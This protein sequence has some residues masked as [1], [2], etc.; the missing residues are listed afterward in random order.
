LAPDINESFRNFSVVPKT[1]KIRFGLFAIKNVG[2]NIVNSI[3]SERKTDGPYKSI[4]DFISRIDS[5][6][7]NK[8]S[9]ESLVKAGVF[10]K[11]AERNQLL[12]NIERLLSYARENKKQKISGQKN[13]FS[14]KTFNSEFYL[15]PARPAKKSEKL[16]WEKELLGLFVTS[17]PLEG[18][19]A[20]LAK[21]A[22]RISELSPSFHY[23]Q[24][25]IGG[26]ISKIKKIITK[27][28][29]PMLFVKLEDLTD[30]IEVVV[31]PKV[32]EQNPAA[33]RE[34]KV[35]LIQGKLD[36]RGG[37]KKL[38]CNSIEEITEG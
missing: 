32:M 33:F 35:V 1:N 22:V 11:F 10:D 30:K 37:E 20:I 2:E 23:N 34:N 5:Q 36:D 7:I 19:R 25:R 6:V 15:E 12:H 26:I 8:K 4:T 27:N 24:V 13:L 18:F 3:I 28:G 31:F 16:N 14:K 17:H 29:K 21:N 38:I 9:L